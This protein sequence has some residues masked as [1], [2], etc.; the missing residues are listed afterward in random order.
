MEGLKSPARPH[1]T[2]EELQNTVAGLVN[3]PSVVLERIAAALKT[4][5]PSEERKDQK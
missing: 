5:A 3:T 4:G 1:R 2:G